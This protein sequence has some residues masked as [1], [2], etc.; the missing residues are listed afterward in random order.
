MCNSSFD[1][2]MWLAGKGG[3]LQQER[4]ESG[5]CDPWYRPD[6]Y[7]IRLPVGTGSLLRLQRKVECDETRAVDGVALAR[8]RSGRAIALVA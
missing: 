6:R 1:P 5:P 3:R 2:G 8:I 4:S 7:S